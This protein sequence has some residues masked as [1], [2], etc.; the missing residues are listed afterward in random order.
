MGNIEW[1]KYM[2]EN[3]RQSAKQTTNYPRQKEAED[4]AKL[5]RHGDSML[6][7]MNPKE[8]ERLYEQGGI[9]INPE[10]GQPEAFLQFLIPVIAA[11]G[12]GVAA[13]GSA[14]AAGAAVLGSAAAAVGAAGGAVIGAVGSGLAAAGTA[15]AGGIGSVAG[16]IGSLFGAGATAG[17]AAGT[18]AAA[19]PT[20]AGL[21]A[22][23]ASAAAPALA[24]QVASAG[25]G[26]IA[27]GGAPLAAAG[28]GVL[29]PG[30]T[31]A[32]GLAG[33]S[34]L[35]ASAIPTVGGAGVMPLG[36]TNL[37]GQFIQGAAPEII[38]NTSSM[39][40]QTGAQMTPEMF[41]AL[42]SAKATEG[43]S[44]F[45]QANQ[46]ATPSV[47][48]VNPMTTGDAA[49]KF[50][51]A[52]NPTLTLGETVGQS[53]AGP[54]TLA[55][56]PLNVTSS[57]ALLHAPNSVLGSNLA[58]SV[59]GLG[60]PLSLLELAQKNKMLTGML[61]YGLGSTIFG[62]EEELEDGTEPYVNMFKEKGLKY[63]P[64]WRENPQ[65]ALNRRKR[66]GPGFNQTPRVGRSGGIT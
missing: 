16:G 45:T 8:V 58:P 52:S 21:T 53:I 43:L 11:V 57:G 64:S 61:L 49:S 51:A 62:D 63:S 56:G 44:A 3:N 34:T 46:F 10:T 35:A 50:Y 18:T 14:V 24:A 12:S 42:E 1:N 19:V 5:G 30:A 23:Q 41:S 55:G 2:L 22:A 54:S 4:L 60:E 38:G 48:L 47:E 27:T 20:A 40:A 25:S 9:T 59:P 7:H 29:L 37:A 66:W 39:L 13:V 15:I 32:A 26:L 31:T 36:Y 6:V 65:A 28:S 17:T 33:P